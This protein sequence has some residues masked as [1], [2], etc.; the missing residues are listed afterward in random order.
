MQL[1]VPAVDPTNSM[2]GAIAIPSNIE[3]C[4]HYSFGVWLVTVEVVKDPETLRR[5]LG[6]IHQFHHATVMAILSRDKKILLQVRLLMFLGMHE[7]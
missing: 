5:Y 7:S 3:K 6:T 4:F 2:W 1:Y